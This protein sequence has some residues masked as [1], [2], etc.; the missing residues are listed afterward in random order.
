MREKPVSPARLQKYID[1]L[2][3]IHENDSV[4]NK[5]NQASLS[6]IATNYAVSS[7]APN[8][9]IKLGIITRESKYVWT[10]KE[11]TR[12]TK[13]HALK[14]LDH[15]LH[16]NKKTLH[17]P[18][19]EFA[20]IAQSLQTIADRLTELHINSER[21]LKRAKNALNGKLEN[22]TDLFRVDDQELYIAGQVAAGVY[23]TLNAGTFN[24]EDVSMSNETIAFITK[25]LMNK[26]RNK[27]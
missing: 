20:G 4:N 7:A 8:A 19:P 11:A 9:L 27:E 18:I 3:S 24:P 1:F 6:T 23:S 26:L 5:S 22:E 12:P 2:Y 25:D 15:L 21:S 16:K 13:T 17:V 14:L 10:W